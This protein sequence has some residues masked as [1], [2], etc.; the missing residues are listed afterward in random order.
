MW[1]NQQW[2]GYKHM[3]V[4][5]FALQLLFVGYEEK[6]FSE[7]AAFHSSDTGDSSL[8]GCHTAAVLR[9]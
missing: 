2:D 5:Y 7:F 8:L 6:Q 3:G 9:V 1:K 4:R